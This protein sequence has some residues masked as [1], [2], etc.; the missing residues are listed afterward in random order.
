LSE[1]EE[2]ERRYRGA[3]DLDPKFALAHFEPSEQAIA[4]G[5][6]AAGQ[7][8]ACKATKTDRN[9]PEAACH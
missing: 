5:Y 1:T 4:R 8:R 3:I 6:M 7:E 2:A 9:D